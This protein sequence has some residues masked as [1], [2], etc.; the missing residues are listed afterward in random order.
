MISPINRTA[1]HGDR[2]L[3]ALW[4]L[5]VVSVLAGLLWSAWLLLL[6]LLSGYL[7]STVLSPIVE[8][9]DRRGMP[10]TLAGA[11]VLG[12]ML[13]SLSVVAWFAIPAILAQIANFQLHS[14]IYIASVETRLQGLMDVLTRLI[15]PA[16]L[17]RTRSAIIHLLSSHGSP[18]DSLQ[19]LFSVLPLLEGILLSLVVTY[20]LLTR[21]SEIRASFVDLVP[22]RYF[23]MTLRLLYRIQRQ[24]SDYI[25]GQ[26]L[27]SVANAILISSALWVLD[28]PYSLLIGVFAGAANVVPLLGPIAGG[29]PAV[30]LAL[31]GATSTPWWVIALTLLVIHM[32]DNLLIYPSTVGE[33]LSLPAW[34]VI[35]GIALGSH[36]GG[37]V[38]M[39]VAVPLLGLTRG[40]LIELHESLKAFR[41]V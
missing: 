31:L 26:S 29:V 20:F 28:V 37:I 14:A 25:R 23:E 13:V 41:I 33:S 27:D 7:L 2:I 22:N 30:V 3:A 6:P 36:V 5:I 18:F 19:D 11:L 24:T 8:S 38:G 12:G 15:P 34:V 32:I 39:L 4:I 9:L 40:F 10:R 16:E 17:A 1:P 35:L 21:G